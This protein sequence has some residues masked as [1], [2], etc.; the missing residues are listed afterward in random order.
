MD[1]IKSTA[2][3]NH[4]IE[5]Y[6]VLEGLGINKVISFDDDW[7]PERKQQI[8]FLKMDIDT[9][10]KTFDIEITE[11][12]SSI[13]S[14]LGLNTV[15]EILASNEKGLNNLN[16]ELQSFI[17]RISKREIDSPLKSLKELFNQI[18]EANPEKI[19]FWTF[20]NYD[21]S[22]LENKTGRNLILLDMN[23]QN[24]GEEKD[25]IIRR[26]FEI[27]SGRE[28]QS[29]IIIVYSNEQGIA[30]YEKHD[31]KIAYVEEYTKR[32]RTEGDD[33]KKVALL[34]Q[35]SKWDILGQNMLVYLI[36]HQL[37]AIKKVSDSKV[38]SNN[39]VERLSKAALGQSLHDFLVTR[40]TNIKEA[41]VDLTATSDDEFELLYRES[42]VEGEQFI[43]VLDRSH[44]NALNKISYNKVQHKDYIQSMVNVLRAVR[45]KNN[46]VI[47]DIKTSCGNNI[48]TFREKVRGEKVTK[49]LYKEEY[50]L[51]DYTVN[52]LNRNIMT[53][54]IFCLTPFDENGKQYFGILVTPDCDLVVRMIN[55]EFKPQSL[56]RKADFA[57]LILLEGHEVDISN[58]SSKEF[59]W[60][61]EGKR[62]NSEE[63][64]WPIKYTNEQQKETYNVLISGN[65]NK[66]QLIDSRILDL[67]SLDKEGWAK[68]A[69]D[70]VQ[71]QPYL[72]YHFEQYYDN[73]LKNWIK[74]VNDIKSYFPHDGYEDEIAATQKIESENDSKILNIFAGLRYFVSLNLQQNRFEI[75]RIGRLDMRRTLSLIQS[76]TS[77]FS[78]VGA[79][80]LPCS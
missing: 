4:V 8:E 48:T 69:S 75:Q 57:S 3:N 78:R 73:V 44:R 21:G 65:S 71:V 46:K 14:N 26:L 18:S 74:G 23:M 40:L 10:T 2:N 68:L 54:D 39:L 33:Q 52:H 67:C 63:L 20:S 25:V 53:G 76:H 79:Q 77:Q 47:K 11:V 34:E 13:I 38:L 29:D 30:S 41:M 80:N 43:D 22:V 51:L 1:E 5:L 16:N 19:S 9:I 35:F 56:G 62:K 64:I 49:G 37:W 7:N 45:Y 6:T 27:Q 24:V 17:E 12:E 55:S 59:K 61:K 15:D 36:P 28:N 58:S 42:F 32:L 70:I 31:D 60:V 66:I 72:T 50:S